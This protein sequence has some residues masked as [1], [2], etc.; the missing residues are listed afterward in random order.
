LEEERDCEEELSVSVLQ[1]FYFEGKLTAKAD[2]PHR[3]LLTMLLMT[4][5]PLSIDIGSTG[6]A[7]VLNST[8]TKTSRITTLTTKLIMTLMSD[9]GY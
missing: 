7:F 9:H 8:P 6:R 1:R 5:L 2:M 3:T 4:T